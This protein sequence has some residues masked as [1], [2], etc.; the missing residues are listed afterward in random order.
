MAT[1]T[2]ETNNII[3]GLHH[4]FALTG[5]T[6]ALIKKE[7]GDVKIS[8]KTFKKCIVFPSYD[9]PKNKFK[10][11]NNSFLLSITFINPALAT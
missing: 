9:L 8:I 11:S 2:T 3:S 6:F 7:N 10:Y 5:E 4:L 1:I